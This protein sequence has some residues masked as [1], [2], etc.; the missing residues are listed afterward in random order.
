MGGRSEGRGYTIQLDTRSQDDKLQAM[1]HLLAVA[2]ARCDELASSGLTACALA[3]VG[4][5]AAALH[6]YMTTQVRTGGCVCGLLF[7]AATAIPL[8]AT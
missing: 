3:A 4:A 1:A 7:R 8:R 6:T 5:A 2:A